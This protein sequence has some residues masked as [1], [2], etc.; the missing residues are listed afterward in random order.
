MSW[1]AIKRHSGATKSKLNISKII[2]QV[3]VWLVLYIYSFIDPMMFAQSYYL[4]QCWLTGIVNWSL[5]IKEIQIKLS[6]IFISRKYLWKCHCKILAHKTFLFSLQWHH[7]GHDCVSN[8]QLQDCL[9]NHLFR[10]RSKKTSK[11]RVTGFLCR[12]FTG[13]FTGDRWIPRTNG[14]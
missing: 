14:Q 1:H 12:E 6:N 10:R 8:H 9:L 7:N 5:G 11:L 13:E 3:L 4:K 2:W